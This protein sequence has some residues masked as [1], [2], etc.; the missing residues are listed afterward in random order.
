[1]SEHIKPCELGYVVFRNGE[2]WKW[3]RLR[4]DAYRCTRLIKVNWHAATTEVYPVGQ[5]GEQQ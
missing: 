5:K 3:F 2:F 4:Q 1:M